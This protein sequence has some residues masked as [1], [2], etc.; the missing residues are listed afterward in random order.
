MASILDGITGVKVIQNADGSTAYQVTVI[1]GIDPRTG[2]QRR[3]YKTFTPPAGMNKREIKKEIER[4][5]VELGDGVTN[6]NSHASR[7]SFAAYAKELIDRRE[8]S[9]EYKSRT[10]TGYRRLLD[11]I[12]DDFGNLPLNEITPETIEAFYDRLRR[13]GSRIRK[14]DIRAN[15]ESIER[16]ME[17][18]GISGAELARRCKISKSSMS[19]T[20]HGAPTTRATAKKMA[21]ELRE[22]IGELFKITA[23]HGGLSEKTILLYSHFIGGV[24][25]SAV[26]KGIVKDNPVNR[27]DRPEAEDKEVSAIQP[28]ELAHI[29]ECLSHEPLK[30]RLVVNLLALTGARR[31]EIAALK[32]DHVDLQNGIIKIEH[33]LS[34]TPERGIFLDSTKTKTV[35]SV[36]IPQEV[37]SLLKQYRAEQ[38]ELI[39]AA[40][41]AYDRQGYLFAQP[42]GKPSNPESITLWLNR[43]SKKYGL[44]GVHAHAFRHCAASLMIAN[45]VDIVT[46]AAILGHADPTTTAKVY[47]HA[48]EEAKVKASECLADAIYTAGS[49]TGSH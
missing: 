37:V 47:A 48:I 36:K 32:W 18:E 10:A 22:D 25:H 39:F 40:G 14:E 4:I 34:Y 16:V 20:I 11:R 2:K 30:W 13:E 19:K 28:E 44:Q 42:D 27:A 1:R 21:N 45:G 43:F 26:K 23:I 46:V 9:G 31:G 38:L 3:R 12:M 29:F 15:T 49:K 17:R 7:Q 35:R 41:P 5:K 33:S 6:T 8:R 24:F